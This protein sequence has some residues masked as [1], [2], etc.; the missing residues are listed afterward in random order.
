MSTIRSFVKR[1]PV[2]LIAALAALVSCFF[3]PPDAGYLHYIDFRTLALLYCLMTVVAGLRQAG[4]F[5]RLA[6]RLCLGAG[7]LRA[8]GILLVLLC[9]GTSLTLFTHLFGGTYNDE[10]ML[11]RY[12]TTFPLMQLMVLF[13][14]SFSVCT[15][16]LQVAL[17]FGARRADY[18]WALQGVL[19]VYTLGCWALAALLCRAPRLLGWPDPAAWE[20]AML[21]TALPWWAFPLCALVMLTMGALCGVKYVRS[22]LV[23]IL[24]FVVFFVVGVGAVV[25]FLL[26][27]DRMFGGDYG[28]LPLLLAAGLTLTFLICDIF[29]CRQVRRAVVTL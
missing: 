18:F 12:F 25:G 20:Q 22:R 28:D 1:E 16:N 5:S 26:T 27:A 29:I 2:L 23:G 21:S 19:G 8:M 7:N 9:F 15:S 6:H 3:V 13:L 17:S 10:S 11:V 14:L 4:L 24:I